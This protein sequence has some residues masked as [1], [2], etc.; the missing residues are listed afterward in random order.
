MIEDVDFCGKVLSEGVYLEFAREIDIYTGLRRTDETI[1]RML[2]ERAGAL[3]EGSSENIGLSDWSHLRLKLASAEDIGTEFVDLTND[4]PVTDDDVERILDLHDDDRVATRAA[5]DVERGKSRSEVEEHS[6]QV[7]RLF[8]TIVLSSKVTRNSELVDSKT[9]KRD[10]VVIALRGWTRM[11]VWVAE[12]IGVIVGE[13]VP[14]GM[15]GR[16]NELTGKQKETLEFL[17]KVVFPISISTAVREAL[18]TEKTTT[19]FR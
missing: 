3:W 9:L 16:I 14:L 11:V 15:R 2:M 19:Y 12:A 7:R 10:A 17:F 6:N 8:S 1:V 5:S 13:N 18:G 4:P